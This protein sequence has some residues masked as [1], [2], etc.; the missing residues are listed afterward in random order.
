MW[1]VVSGGTTYEDFNLKLSAVTR[2]ASQNDQA[3]N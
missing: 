3:V 1:A 2:L